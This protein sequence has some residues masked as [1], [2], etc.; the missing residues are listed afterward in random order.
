MVVEWFE[1]E[2][3]GAGG[4][5]PRASVRVLGACDNQRG[6]G[7]LSPRRLQQFQASHAG[8][9]YVD[10]KAVDLGSGLTRKVLFRC[11]EEDDVKPGRPEQASERTTNRNIVVNHTDC[12]G[13]LRHN[14][15]QEAAR[16]SQIG[17]QRSQRQSGQ[18]LDLGLILR[19]PRDG[20]DLAIS[21]RRTRSAADSN[22]SFSMTRPR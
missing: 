22:C 13:S 14:V 3:D 11:R 10:G 9:A 1:E 2:T 15:P 5:R 7:V 12:V 8:E 21:A 17:R 18:E 4:H 16:I 19:Q 20:K 6:R